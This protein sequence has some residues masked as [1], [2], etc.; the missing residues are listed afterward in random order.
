MAGCECNSYEVNDYIVP[1]VR[2]KKLADRI[3]WLSFEAPELA[4]T[5]QAGLSVMVF[6][7]EGADPLLGRPFAVADANP[8]YGEISVC[9]MLLGRGTE[10]LSRVPEGAKLRVRGFLGV[11][12]PK[13]EETL[14]LAGGGAGCA[15]LLMKKRE[16]GEKARL[17][18]GTPGKG[19]KKFA[20]HLLSLHPDAQIF[21]D[22]GSFG[23]GDS[24]FKKLPAPLGAGEQAWF[25]G[26]PGFLKAAEKHYAASPERLYFL[27]DKRMACGYGG[28]MGCVIETKNGLK[29]VC[30]DQSVFRSDEVDINDN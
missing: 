1:V 16:M 22:D 20:E 7:S 3:F 11:P 19:Y 8:S 30:V 28:C 6:P 27:L 4:R 18:V 13:T 10:M 17:C 24:M 14:Y 29:R 9:F 23:E 15:A 21:A 26:P 25:C 5:A 12:Y 2:N